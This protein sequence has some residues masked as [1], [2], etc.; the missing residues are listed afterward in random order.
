M[1]NKRE[2]LWRKSAD[3]WRINCNLGESRSFKSH[4]GKKQAEGRRTGRW[5]YPEVQ[6]NPTR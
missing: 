1:L 2:E 4:D 3:M 5:L 6:T